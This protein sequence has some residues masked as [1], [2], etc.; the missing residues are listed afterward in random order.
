MPDNE[1]FSGIPSLDDAQ[2]LEAYINQQNLEAMGLENTQLAGE[3]TQT[4]EGAQTD[5]GNDVQQ[6]Y[7]SEQVAQI[8]ARNQQLENYIAGQAQ[9][10][11]QAQVQQQQ[12]Q[13]R[14]SDRQIAIINELLRRGVPMERISQAMSKGNTAGTDALQ[15]VQALE[16]Y[17]QQE[18]YNKAAEEFEHKMLNFGAKFGLSENEL[19]HFGNVAYSKGINIANVTDLEAVFS[20]LFPE[21]Y[22]LRVQRMSNRPTSQIYGGANIG[23][24]PRAAANKLEDAYVEAFLAKSMPNQYGMFNKK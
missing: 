22:A 24:A 20:G 12:P 1:I 15:R 16:R 8:I 14:Y 4:N 6:P 17:I 21:Q 5:V 23:E 11:Q 3:Q 10:R 9:A 7:T 2:G 18:Q 13:A 19:V